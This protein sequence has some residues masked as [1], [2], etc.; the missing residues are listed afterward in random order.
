MLSV[1]REPISGQVVLSA[2]GPLDGRSVDALIQALTL[3]AERAA[4]VVDLSR[5]QIS[6]PDSLR[7]LAIALA[8][9]EGKVKFLGPTWAKDLR[10]VR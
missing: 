5:A 9:R 1:T 3:T 8:R 2:H 10:P 7:R 4:I 6:T